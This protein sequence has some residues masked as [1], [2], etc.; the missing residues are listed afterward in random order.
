MIMITG[1]RMSSPVTVR[2][3]FPHPE[4]FALVPAMASI[5]NSGDAPIL[6]M[7]PPDTAMIMVSLSGVVRFGAEPTG[8]RK[9]AEA[10]ILHGAS[11][12]ARWLEGGRGDMFAIALHP[13]AWPLWFARRADDFAD[14]SVPLSMLLGDQAALLTTALAGAEDFAVRA[15]IANAWL[16]ALPQHEIAPALSSQIMAVRMGL[17]DPDCASVEALAAR[18]ALSPSQ[19]SRLTRSAFG[20]TPKLLI[21]R[22]RF[23]RMLHHADASSYDRWRDFIEG[24]YVDQSHLIRDFQ[25]FLGLSPS[26]YF[27][28]ERPVVAAAFAEARRLL[29]VG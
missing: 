21:Q 23:R 6:D 8:L 20:F 29:G 4:L 17:S 5:A 1:S 27:A 25:R 11:S 28:L 14:A 26:R 2:Y 24:Q 12:H 10:A 18:A 13:L 16:K 9:G 19:L 22:E 15:E 3:C 7:A